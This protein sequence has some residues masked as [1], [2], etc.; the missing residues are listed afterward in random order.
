MKCLGNIV[1][2]AIS[3]VI[4]LASC[5]RDEAE[6]IP[7]DDLARIYAEMLLTDQ[8][9]LNTPNV[10]LI[11]D[12]SLVYDPILESYGYD[13]DDYRKSVDRYMDDPERFAK[14]LRTSGEIL[15]GRL[16][17]LELRKAELERL[18]ILRREAEKYR[19][20][21]KWEK[22]YMRRKDRQYIGL[23][24]SLVFEMDSTG[25]FNISYIERDDTLYDGV[26]MV[27]NEKKAKKAKKTLSAEKIDSVTLKLVDT[28]P[29]PVMNKE[30]KKIVAPDFM[31]I[32]N[33][34]K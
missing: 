6:V 23:S 19:P 1:S 17:D 7:R 16:K 2:L 13:A 12:T 8:W 21:I 30:R 18:K 22:V 25:R 27:L 9:I 5:G 24:D 32:E 4:L 11:A 14:I 31:K 20:D 28:L 10:R 15:E 26:R 3:A 34:R 29:L 33:G